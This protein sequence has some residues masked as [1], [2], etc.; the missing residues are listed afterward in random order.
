MAGSSYYSPVVADLDGDLDLEIRARVEIHGMYFLLVVSANL[1][2]FPCH[3]VT[4]RD[5]IVTAPAG[6]DQHPASPC[7]RRLLNELPVAWWRKRVFARL[8]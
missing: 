6:D 8:S 5:R 2:T 7:R 3:Q 1:L 4:F